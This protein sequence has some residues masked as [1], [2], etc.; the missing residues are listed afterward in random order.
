[1]RAR[2][3]NSVGVSARSR[4]TH[5]SSV[6][7]L[8]LLHTVTFTV[9]NSDAS[10]SAVTVTMKRWRQSASTDSDAVSRSSAATIA[11]DIRAMPPTCL[12]TGGSKGVRLQLLTQDLHH[13]IRRHLRE[14]LHVP[15]LLPLLDGQVEKLCHGVGARTAAASLGSSALKHRQLRAYRF[16]RRWRATTCSSLPPCRPGS[17]SRA[18]STMIRPAVS[19]I[20]AKLR[21]RLA[22]TNCF[23][24]PHRN[25]PCSRAS[26]APDSDVAC[27][28]L[29]LGANAHVIGSGLV[30]G[31]L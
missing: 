29:L 12:H 13:R 19:C 24:L 28:Q 15:Q 3:T 25:F 16:P 27:L 30:V 5:S 17:H 10:S 26:H 31:P 4:F 20:H 22:G 18:L 6:A 7:H 1:V 23:P 9:M 8:F 11:T 2:E 21:F 14:A